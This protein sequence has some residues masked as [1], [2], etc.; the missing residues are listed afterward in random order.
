[1]KVDNYESILVISQDL[2]NIVLEVSW[3][4]EKVKRHYLIL[5]M[6]I[7]NMKCCLL[8]VFFVNS[9]LIIYID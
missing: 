8:L 3:Y 7:S 2:V 5:K 9:Y 6:T 4:I 1:M